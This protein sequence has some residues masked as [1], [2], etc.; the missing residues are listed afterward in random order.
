MPI[1]REMDRI[2]GS[3]LVLAKFNLD[4]HQLPTRVY[5]KSLIPTQGLYL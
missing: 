5:I 2:V 3:A 4:R 1:G